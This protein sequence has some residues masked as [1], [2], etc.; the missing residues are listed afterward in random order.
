MDRKPFDQNS[1][2]DEQLAAF[3]EG[4]SSI[5]DAYRSASDIEPPVSL[6]RAILHE[7]RAAV[8]TESGNWLAVEL[9]FWRHWARPITAVAMMGF[10]VALVLE[11]MEFANETASF[12][13]A[14]LLSDTAQEKDAATTAAFAHQRQAA[15]PAPA[16]EME[17]EMAP[18]PPVTDSDTAMDAAPAQS[19][20]GSMPASASPQNQPTQ[21]ARLRAAPPDLTDAVIAG[22]Y[23][24]DEAEVAASALDA[25][26]RGA[27]PAMTVWLAGIDALRKSG[28][29]AAADIEFALLVTVYPDAAPKTVSSAVTDNAGQRQTELA[30]AAIAGSA[31]PGGKQQLDEQQNITGTISSTEFAD[32]QVWAAGINWLTSEGQREQA[33]IERDKL[34]QIYPDF[35]T[36]SDTD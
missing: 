35:F 16:M 31:K 3:L 10:C 11:V 27:R 2:S 25:W 4:E 18:A 8:K 13:D 12:P 6:D 30:E 14:A 17:M 21:T 7:A 20:L 1:V 24:A 32:P 28:Q 19:D 15:I 36:V 26:N 23:Q 34:L 22:P 29:T 5:S 33:A 9:R